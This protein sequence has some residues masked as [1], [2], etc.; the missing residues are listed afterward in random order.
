MPIGKKKRFEIFKRD[1]FKCQYCGESAPDVVLEADHIKPKKEGGTDDISNLITSCKD[2]NRGKGA[3]L[4]DD[5]SVIEKQRKQL[6]GL[7]ER[8]VQLEMMMEWREGLEKLND[9]VLDTAVRHFE[10]K[11]DCSL[12]ETGIKSIK[13]LVKKYPPIT[14]LEAIDDACSQYLVSGKKNGYTDESQD[15]TFKYVSKI[16]HIKAVD[17]E[18]PYLK[19]LFYIRGILRNRLNY[20]DVPVAL[21]L[22]ETAYLGGASIESLKSLAVE[23]RNWSAWREAIEEFIEGCE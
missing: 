5:K 7:N 8:R 22:L 15:N 18:K 4:L 12:T 19:D 17:K 9:D 20:L 16:C 11:A 1:S 3:R 23:T 10:Q 6:E 21:R 2:C 14:I 13:K